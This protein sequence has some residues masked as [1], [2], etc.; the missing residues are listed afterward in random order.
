MSLSK[1]FPFLFLTLL[2]YPLQKSNACTRFVYCGK[3]H[4]VFTARSMDWFEDVHSDLWFYPRGMKKDGGVGKGSIHWISKYASVT[5]SGYDIGTVD[6]LNEKGL[7]ANLLYLSETDFGNSGDK[8]GLSVG[9]WA[10][11]VLDNYATVDEAIENLKTEPFRII[12]STLPSGHAPGLHLSLSDKTGN[13]GILEYINGKLIIHKGKEHAVMTNSPTYDQQIALNAYWENIGGMKMLPG[14]NRASDRYVRA[15]F[16]SKALPEFEDNRLAVS[17]T[18]SVIRNVSVPL[19]IT[20]PDQPNIASTIWRS[21]SDHKNLI[22]FYESAISPNTFWVDLK[23][24]DFST[25]KV[26]KKID[27]DGHPILT[28][29]V[30]DKFVEAKPFK[31]LAPGKN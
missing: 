18:F 10:Q 20:D 17:A 19:G 8:P 11:F 16:Y 1:T 14:T 31:W 21:V 23:K 30:S 22:Y 4:L 5:V 3:D 28:G 24:F 6:G 9:A 27:L 29:E 25:T 26:P 13:S 15:S 7:V 12:A 2:F